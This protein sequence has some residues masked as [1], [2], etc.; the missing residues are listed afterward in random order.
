MQSV[1]QPGVPILQLVVAR[2]SGIGPHRRRE[3]KPGPVG[4][5]GASEAGDQAGQPRPPERGPA[6]AELVDQ[7]QRRRRGAGVEGRQFPW[8]QLGDQRGA[9]AVERR[10]ADIE[11]GRGI[12]DVVEMQTIERVG[13]G[14]VI[15]RR[16]KSGLCPFGNRRRE[17]PFDRGRVSGAPRRDGREIAGVAGRQAEHGRGQLPRHHHPL[18]VLHRDV[19]RSHGHG[20]RTGDQ[21]DVEPGVHLHASR[22]GAL[23]QFGERIEGGGLPGKQRGTRVGP[24]A[25]EGVAAATDLHEDGVEAVA[26]GVADDLADLRRRGHPAARDPQAAHLAGRR[27]AHHRRAGPGRGRDYGCE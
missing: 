15:D 7:G 18:G 25:V 24:T 13:G 3:A 2:L 20:R 22:T 27:R 26:L 6:A 10:A 19:L 23:D 8:R 12:P 14:E 9:E 16:F 4:S 17:D 21:I 11:V 5:G 1:T